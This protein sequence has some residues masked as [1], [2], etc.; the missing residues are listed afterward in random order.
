MPLHPAIVHFPIALVSLAAVMQFLVVVLKRA[1]LTDSVLITLGLGILSA[2]AAALTGTAQEKV[3]SD[4]P[5]IGNALDLHGVLGNISTWLLLAAGFVVLF[6]HLKGRLYPWPFL[7]LLILLSALL[8][9]TGYFGAELVYHYG[10][11][12]DR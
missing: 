3:A 2:L 8:I 4:Q 11:G 10:A 7:I 9:I 5:G 6:L 12:V 1:N